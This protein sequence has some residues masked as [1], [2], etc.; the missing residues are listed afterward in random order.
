M[1]DFKVQYIHTLVAGAEGVDSKS[2]LKTE[3]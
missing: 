3:I 1:C 2:N